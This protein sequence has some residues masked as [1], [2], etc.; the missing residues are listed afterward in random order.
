MDL[1]QLQYFLA[2]AEQGSMT[3]A[4][5]SLFVSQPNLSVS[6]SRLEEDLGAEL[7]VRRKGKIA[8]T[9]SGQIFLKYVTRMFAEL[10]K[11]VDRLRAFS[12]DSSNQLSIATGLTDLVG[13]VIF[14]MS[15]ETKEMK[16]KQITCRNDM[17]CK[18]V[19]NDEADVGIMFGECTAENLE[20]FVLAEWD[21]IV[22]VNENHPL[23]YK[24]KVSL[25]EIKDYPF[26]YN[27]Q[28]DDEQLFQHLGYKHGIY[29]NIYCD[30]DDFVLESAML[31][32]NEYVAITAMVNFIKL[33]R[34][35]PDLPLK[36]IALTDQL[37]TCRLGMVRRVGHRLT[38]SALRF[39]AA[40]IRFFEEEKNQVAIFNKQFFE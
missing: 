4:A 24:K 23:A 18:I 39:E 10:E 35:Y 1:L 38:N 6:M 33:L 11:G 29:P 3:G 28:R 12:T 16:L 26:I 19:Q 2:I 36:P 8:L 13:S 34:V 25:A 7:F 9:E 37:P 22:L 20:Y 15:E 14:S 30:I 40:L 32:H 31:C 27:Q 5:K 17:I 21:R